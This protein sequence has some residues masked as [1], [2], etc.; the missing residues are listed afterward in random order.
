MR[1]SS[2]VDVVNSFANSV[3]G[4]RG[5]DGEVRHGHVVVNGTYKAN[6]LEVCMFAYLVLSDLPLLAKLRYEPRPFRTEHVGTSKRTIST[7]YNERV[8]ALLDHVVRSGESSV[9]SPERRGARSAN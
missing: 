7:A 1:E 6:D 9:P 3:K 4:R 8:D 5:T 2:R